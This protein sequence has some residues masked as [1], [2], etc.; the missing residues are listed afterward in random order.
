MNIF[1]GL[2][3]LGFDGLEG[4]DIFDEELEEKKKKEQEQH[5]IQKPKI[6]EED[7]VFDK[8]MTCP[9]CDKNFTTKAVKTG[10]AKLEGTDTDLRPRYE[11]VDSLKYDAV[12]CPYCG[13]ANFSRGFQ[14]ILNAQAKLV[15]EQIT[16]NF[17]GICH[18]GAIYSYDESIERHKMV[19]LNCVVKKGKTSERAYACLKLAWILRGKAESL[20]EDTPE[21]KKAKAALKKEELD[22][23]GKA[24][25]GFVAA[26][27][28]ESF[29]MCGM[30]D[31]TVT[32]LAADLA[33][34][35]GKYNEANALLSRVITSRT[36]NERIKDKARTIRDM[37]KEE[38]KK[39]DSQV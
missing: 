31:L 14:N 28:K 18:D 24:Y 3:G 32:Y 16:S 15:K 23:L 11:L 1:S 22:L 9:V 7:V 39:Q 4:F 12:V 21:N 25:Y 2:E 27:P 5:K 34:Q 26:F 35:I 6:K 29:P 33:R 37:I 17:K 36:A 30:D 10:K 8:T 19:L 38:K 13:Y 20:T